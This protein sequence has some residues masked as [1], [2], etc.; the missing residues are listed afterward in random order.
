MFSFI[1]FIFGNSTFYSCVSGLSDDSFIQKGW[2]KNLKKYLWGNLLYGKY[3][4]K[5]LISKQWCFSHSDSK[6]LNLMNE[7]S[8][9]ISCMVRHT[10]QNGLTR[11]K[12]SATFASR[13]LKNSDHFGKSWRKGLICQV[14]AWNLW[15]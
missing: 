6:A 14:V 10:S 2:I 15:K 3:N 9:S 13:F 4:D 8:L 12:N 11:F 1:L 5:C 7:A